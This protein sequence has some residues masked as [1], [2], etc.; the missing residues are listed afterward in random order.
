MKLVAISDLHVRSPNDDSY[1]LLIDFLNHKEVQVATDVCFL[2]DIFD[3]L[4]GNHD[5][6]IYL[7]NDFFKKIIEMCGFGKT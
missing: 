7:Y 1:K 3:A 5:H 2:G 6:Y 4:I